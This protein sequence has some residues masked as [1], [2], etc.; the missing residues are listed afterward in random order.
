[1]Y[2]Y[3]AYSIY[4]YICASDSIFNLN[5][6]TSF[7]L[8]RSLY[9]FFSFSSSLFNHSSKFYICKL[10]FCFIIFVCHFRCVE[11][12]VHSTIHKWTFENFLTLSCDLSRTLHK[13]NDILR[14]NKWSSSF[15]IVWN[16]NI[17]LYIY[18]RVHRTLNVDKID[19][20]TA[21]EKKN[22][23]LKQQQQA[24]T[25]STFHK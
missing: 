5:I 17:Y 6:S 1:M 10:C 24:A 2:A 7:F 14:E 8:S 9:R 20:S 19:A 25:V 11:T 15:N 21:R 23:N 16:D 4:I 18:I 22:K 12:F 13:I 3:S